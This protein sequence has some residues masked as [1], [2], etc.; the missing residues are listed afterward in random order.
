[1]TLDPDGQPLRYGKPGYR[2]PGFAATGGA[3][4]PVLR[5]LC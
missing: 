3:P 5:P 1:M 2:N 4:A